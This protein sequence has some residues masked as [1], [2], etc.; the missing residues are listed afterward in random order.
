MTADIAPAQTPEHLR[1]A[2]VSTLLEQGWIT[3]DAV[4]VAFA[5]VPR[6]RFAPEASPEAAHAVNDV[7][8]TKR[9]AAGRAMSSV[10]APWLQAAMLERAALRPGAK[11]LEIGSGGCN[12]ALIAELV[13]PEGVVVSV[14][15]DPF[16]TERAARFLAET[17]YGHVQVVLGD[18]EH[19]AHAHAPE[20]GF[21]AIMVTVGVWDVPWSDL[22][23]PGG[24]LVVPL[25]FGTVTRCFTF[26]VDG[27][28]LTA[29]DATVCGFVPVQGAGAFQDQEAELADGAVR[30]TREAGPALDAA[31]LDR[32]LTGERT[33]LWTGV[34]V[35]YGESFDSMH[36]YLA[37][38]DDRFGMIW[39]DRER[40]GN[41]LVDLALRW[42]CPVLITS[43]SFAYLTLRDASGDARSKGERRLEFG[44]HGHGPA[45]PALAEDL[46]RHVLA[47]DAGWRTRADP[48]FLLYP[49]DAMVPPPR[50]GKIFIKRHTKLA[51][52]WS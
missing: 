14:D 19:V 1:T 44:A 13:G 11:A 36:L 51:L 41:D 26:V 48:A 18:A 25:R 7:V 15:I 3:S 38:T 43:D 28:H 46:R 37:S 42:S 12:A 16:V 5:A 31:A 52:T 24:R 17:G 49:A 33:E 9:N 10:S 47:W 32:A 21:D 8:V 34:M 6:E 39:A 40:G 4:R 2:M 29:L 22:L 30:L 23:A 27:D 35:G 20:G 50:Q 45:G